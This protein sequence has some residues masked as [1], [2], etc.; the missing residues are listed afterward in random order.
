[1]KTSWLSIK[2]Q[3]R[4]PTS[5]A[6][7]YAS[8]AARA[9]GHEPNSEWLARLCASW[10]VGHGAMPDYLGLEP[11]EFWAL[12]DRYFPGARLSGVAASG[13]RIDFTRMLERGDL[14]SLLL[15]HAARPGTQEARWLSDILLVGCMGGEHLWQDLGLW[16]RADL[17]GLIAHNFPLLAARNNRNMKWKKFFYKQLCEAEGIYVCRAPSCEV[18]SDYPKCFGPED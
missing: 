11:E 5:R 7:V 18:C 15:R 4:R 10:L 14:R 3:R 12:A 9:I 2:A 13:L 16:S 8:L 6:S 1:M 17:S